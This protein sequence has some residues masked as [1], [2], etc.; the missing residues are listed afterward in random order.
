M[1]DAL[2]HAGTLKTRLAGFIDKAVAGEITNA[3]FAQIEAKLLPQI[4]A[5][6]AKARSTV[7][8]PL[9]AELAGS[10]AREKWEALPA[11]DRRTVV[12]SLL[13]VKILKARKGNTRRFDPEDIEV[14]WRAATVWRPRWPVHLDDTEFGESGLPNTK[15]RRVSRS[16]HRLCDPQLHQDRRRNELTDLELIEVPIVARGANPAASISSIKSATPRLS[17]GLSSA[18]AYSMAIW[19]SRR[20]SSGRLPVLHR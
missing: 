12:Q 4:A 13:D 17:I 8:S 9:V 5:A 16:E 3:S 19:R 20:G 1:A 18:T 2:A 6:E 7:T 14:T 15:G 11:K 10:D